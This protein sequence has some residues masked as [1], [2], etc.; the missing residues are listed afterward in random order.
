MADENTAPPGEPKDP[1]AS[2]PEPSVDPLAESAA[3]A[4]TTP[5]ASAGAM[6]PGQRLA[7]KKALK[8]TQKREFK[9]ELR[10][11]EELKRQQEQ[12][13]A[14]RL[15]GRAPV[16]PVL[17]QNVEKAASKFTTFLQ[18]HRGGIVGA[19]LGAVAIAGAVFA[20]RHFMSAGSQEQ[21]TQLARAVELSNAAI[22]ADDTDGKTDD[23]KPLFKSESERATKA[24]G[25]F[26]E[27][28]KI[29][30]DS[31]AARWAKLGQA[32]LQLLTG[33]PAEA[34]ASYDSAAQGAEDVAVRAR[35]MEG[36]AIALEAENKPDEALKVFEQLKALEGHKE[37]GDYHIARLRL[38]KGDRDGAKTLLKAL[39]DQLNAPKEGDPPRPYLKMEVELRL[40][41][42]DSSLV[43]QGS[44]MQAPQQFSDEQLQRL[45][46][47]LQ[48]GKAP[49]APSE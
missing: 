47:Q 21:A 49:G 43:D 45:I 26:G 34:R 20:A 9:E 6:T 24:A 11:E 30:A 8:A 15:L 17:P 16:E 3:T 48:K 33:K 18:D 38:S 39:Y 14:D 13:E 7:A 46:E 12:E 42:L 10:R 35:S 2:S 36:K 37:L 1:D 41:E 29:E 27:A 40:A 4:G 44:S 32:A 31:E 25:A 22:D 23:G 28:V 19:L 5:A